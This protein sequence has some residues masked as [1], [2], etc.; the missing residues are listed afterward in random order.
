MQHPRTVWISLCCALIASNLFLCTP[1]YAH[2]VTKCAPKQAEL[3]AQAQT[4]HGAQASQL[5]EDSPDPLEIRLPAPTPYEANLQGQWRARKA[6]TNFHARHPEWNV[7]FDQHTGQP[8]RL[9]GP[10][11]PMTGNN[12]VLDF[13]RQECQDFGMPVDELREGSTYA[14]RKYRYQWFEQ[15]HQ[16]LQVIGGRLGFKRTPEGALVWLASELHPGI[17]ISTVASIRPSEAQ[18][19]ASVGITNIQAV[20]VDPALKILPVPGKEAMTV[21]Y[22]LVYNIQVEGQD[23]QGIPYRYACLVDAQTG[24]LWQRENKVVEFAQQPPQSNGNL[25]MLGRVYP[26]HPFAPLDSA[27]PL[28]HLKFTIGGNTYYTSATGS[29]DMGLPGLPA[30]GIFPLE[31]RFSKVVQGNNGT[32]TPTFSLLIDSLRDTIQYYGRGTSTSLWN[33]VPHLSAYYHTTKVHDYMK[34]F[35]PTFTALDIPLTTKVERTDGN[36]NAFFNGNSI[37]F[38]TQ[39][40]GCNTLAIVADVVYHEYG[41]AITNYFYNALGTQ[42]RNGA[43]GE[44]YS[45]VYAI[46]L[47]DTPVLGVGF[48]LNSP[49]VIVRRYDINPKIYPQN[50]VGQVHADGEIICGAWWRTARNM[51]SNSGMMEIFSES[52]YGLANGPNGS[53][54]VVYTDILIDALQADDN[55]NNLANGT[56]NLN[57]IVNAFAFH[58]IRML[59]NVQFSYPPL[60]DIPAQTPAQFNV[61]LSIT[62]PFNTLISG[63]KLIYR[64]NNLPLSTCDTIALTAGAG[65]SY[66]GVIPAQPRGTIVRYFVGL[67]DLTGA[68]GGAY[69]PFADLSSSPGLWFNYLVGFQNTYNLDI[70]NPTQDS[71]WLIGWSTD[72]AV[73]GIW[74]IGTPI[75]SY[76]TPGSI[77]TIVQTGSNATPGGSRCAYTGN[78]LSPSD[79]P[80]SE[81]VDGGRTTLRTPPMDMTGMADPV[82]AYQRWYTNDMGDNPNTDFLEVYINN[83]TTTWKLVERT[84]RSDRQWRR[85]VFRVADYVTPNATVQLRF[86]A[87]DQAPASIV[88]AAIDQIQHFDLQWGAGMF[89][90]EFVAWGLRPNPFDGLFTLQMESPKDQVVSLVLTNTR[91]VTVW[92][93]QI[94]L[95]AGTNL[96]DLEIPGLAPGLYMARL[97]G[98]NFQSRVLKMVRK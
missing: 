10:A 78:A 93:K 96:L 39:A 56:P 72:N 85:N 60:A 49:N 16:G 79:D 67:Q 18:R 9:F 86:I 81:D 90:P 24:R 14:S 44:G 83:G 70:E 20:S 34:S 87:N 25:T 13:V 19:L 37:N 41:H 51:N 76:V 33:K 74:E 77:A 22:H 27:M 63:A 26:K 84:N 3:G 62:P 31:G 59:A 94:D 54:G 45:D 66:S 48:N 98:K 43:V 1:T 12:P 35:L 4:G 55:D 68:S 32:T 17:Q 38:Y 64:L 15:W 5:T 57:A 50:L 42:F 91:G 7:L 30:T 40:G 89:Q 80:D 73:T 36:C 58:G 11:L 82:L 61:T 53:E 21:S 95:R 92:S 71:T 47:T 97:E 75:P 8:H 2:G 88:E 28:P 46:T 65:N 23:N 69:P 29:Y 6:W 52:L